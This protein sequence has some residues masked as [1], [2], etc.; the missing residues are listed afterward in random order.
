MIGNARRQE[1]KAAVK[2]DSCVD[3]HW[4]LNPH[5]LSRLMQ[6]TYG[7]SGGGLSLL[8]AANREHPNPL[9]HGWET[10]NKTPIRNKFVLAQTA[11]GISSKNSRLYFL[12]CGKYKVQ[13]GYMQS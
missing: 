5:T 11:V 13:Y 9:K 12:F 6:G 8:P 1:E 10:P 2:A 3:A 4:V 7:A